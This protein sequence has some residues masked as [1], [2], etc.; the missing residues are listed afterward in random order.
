MLG[1]WEG[2][3]LSPASFK[4]LGDRVMVA[5]A[6]QETQTTTGIALTDA[7]SSC[8]LVSYRCVAD[9]VIGVWAQFYNIDEDF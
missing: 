7:V 1:V 4:P 3:T 2:G 6:E 5:V 9:S 8:V